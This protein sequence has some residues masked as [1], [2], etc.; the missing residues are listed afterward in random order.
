V[1]ALWRGSWWPGPGSWRRRRGPGRQEE[2]RLTDSSCGECPA[3]TFFV[4]GTQTCNLV[5]PHGGRVH[6]S[7]RLPTPTGCRPWVA[8]SHGMR[9][10]THA[11]ISAGAQPARGSTC[12]KSTPGRA[13]PTPDL[14]AAQ[15]R[16]R[17]QQV[18]LA[19]S[20]RHPQRR[21]R[22][23]GRVDTKSLQSH[24]PARHRREGMGTA[25]CASHTRLPRLTR[26]PE[27]GTV[28]PGPR[29]QQ[30]RRCLVKCLLQSR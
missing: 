23:D 1:E 16:C 21:P 18:R 26:C 4:T 13:P 19:S 9:Q 8:I 30:D 14:T 3:Q 27:L 5:R 25:A 17:L 2:A 6:A 15:S 7:H 20:R 22:F 28:I 24:H 11:V 29:G 10:Q 12:C